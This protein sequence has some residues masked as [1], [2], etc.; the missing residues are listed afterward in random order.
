[1]SLLTH[2]QRR[3]FKRSGFL[4]VDGVLDD[5]LVTQAREAVLADHVPESWDHLEEMIDTPEEDL[6]LDAEGRNVKMHSG[7]FKMTYHEEAFA[8]IN[9]Q[10]YPYAE[11]LVGEGRLTD[12]SDTGRIVLRFPQPD[13]LTTPD[14]EQAGEINSHIDGVNVGSRMPTF[15]AAI[16]LNRIQP[17][18]GGF[19][20]WPGSHHLVGKYYREAAGDIYDGSGGIPAL[21]ADGTWTDDR[22]LSEQ[23]DPIEVH[24]DPGTVVL[25][26]GH[27]EH[28][29]GINLSPGTVRIGQFTRYRLREELYDDAMDYARHPFHYW[30]GLR[31]IDLP[32]MPGYPDVE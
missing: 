18:G 12:P 10:L 4:V 5:E 31:D 26:H 28:T 29:G 14:A 30:E 25:W 20:V 17:R 15:G 11:E 27:M 8:R 13:T 7:D 6:P 19:T 32:E 16:Y 1:M 22:Q 9:E 3:E 2:E 21:N 24:G 23:F